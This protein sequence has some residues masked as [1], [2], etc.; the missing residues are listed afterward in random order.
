MSDNAI[1]ILVGRSS[2]WPSRSFRCPAGPCSSRT[3][4]LGVGLLARRDGAHRRGCSRSQGAGHDQ[5]IYSR[6]FGLV[7]GDDD[8]R[9]G[10]RRRVG[11]LFLEFILWYGG[12]FLPLEGLIVSDIDL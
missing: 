1:T 9:G 12:K 5:H 7:R 2:A 6:V 10:E 11:Q 3:A 4:A 8:G